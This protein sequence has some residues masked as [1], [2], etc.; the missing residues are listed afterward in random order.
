M[1]IAWFCDVA[2]HLVG[3]LPVISVCI[4]VPFMDL[5]EISMSGCV[6]KRILMSYFMV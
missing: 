2:V 3:V 4:S 5:V 1:L 6:K